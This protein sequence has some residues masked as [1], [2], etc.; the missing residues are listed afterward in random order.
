MAP[1]ALSLIDAA[2]RGALVVLLLLLVRAMWRERSRLDAAL[3]GSA[4]ALGLVVQVV[5]GTPTINGGLGPGWLALPVGVSVANSVLFWLFA[6]AMFD[7]SF[8][9]RPG[10]AAVWLAVAVVGAC[11]VLLCRPGVPLS[12]A[13]WALAALK[14]WLP[15][16]FAMLA[17]AA[18]ARQWRSDLVEGRRRLRLFVVAAGVVN[19]AAM[20][21]ARLAAPR[22]RIDGLA[23]WMDVAMLLV[24]AAVMAWHLLRPSEEALF[25]PRAEPAASATDAG[26]TGQVSPDVVAAIDDPADLP[27]AAHLQRIME[28]ERVY[29]DEALSVAGLAARLR[30]PEYRLRRVIHRR[31]G[32]RNFSAYVN[33]YRLAEARSALADPG[34][35]ELPVLTL[36]LEAGFG[37]IGP[38]NRAFKADTGLTPTEYRR[39]KLADS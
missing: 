35:R 6:C 18:A 25:S 39:G 24:I 28:V 13:L 33:G 23:A 22:G 37:S 2:T 32:F 14:N 3:T 34:R 29:K 30:V 27:L 11:G 38:F 15:L 7:D 26:L 17:L 16:V 12:D 9:A 36:A 5:F 1:N 21:A 19:T 31:L 4:L 10:H 8:V 20:M